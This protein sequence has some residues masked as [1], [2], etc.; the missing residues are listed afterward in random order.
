MGA[1]SS[2]CAIDVEMVENQRIGQWLR[3]GVSRANGRL[4]SMEVMPGGAARTVLSR[5][6][7]VNRV[8]WRGGVRRGG[9]ESTRGPNLSDKFRTFGS[10]DIC[11]HSLPRA[12]WANPCTVPVRISHK[13]VAQRSRAS[14]IDFSLTLF[15]L[16]K[17]SSFSLKMRNLAFVDLAHVRMCLCVVSRGQAAGT[18]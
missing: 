9:F 16:A 18:E 6:P 17:P 4:P 10:S 7:H 3:L 1:S 5:K 2:R 11:H 14:A 15:S 8:T 13:L 12:S